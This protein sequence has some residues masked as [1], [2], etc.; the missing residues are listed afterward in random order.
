[1]P[2]LSFQ[3]LFLEHAQE[4]RAA[5]VHVICLGLG[6]FYIKD[7]TQPALGDLL[8]VTYDSVEVLVVRDAITP[9]R[10]GYVKRDLVQRQKRPIIEAKETP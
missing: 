5:H 4:H 1:M 8:Q 9:G 10:K 6:F 3:S 2:Q 7:L